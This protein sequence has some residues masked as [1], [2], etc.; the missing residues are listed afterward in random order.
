MILN[1]TDGRRLYLPRLSTFSGGNIDKTV[2]LK[3]NSPWNTV[4]VDPGGPVDFRRCFC[5]G[6]VLSKVQILWKNQEIVAVPPETWNDYCLI[7][8]EMSGSTD[9]LA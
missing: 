9:F 6:Q 3:L 7:F 8:K 5:N 4:F 2:N 1:S